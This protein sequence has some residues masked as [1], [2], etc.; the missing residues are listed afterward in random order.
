[1]SDTAKKNLAIVTD[2]SPFSG[3]ILAFDGIRGV[4]A[5]Y[6]VW[7]HL[8][9]KFVVLLPSLMALSWLIRY[10]NFAVSLFFLIS[11]FLTMLVSRR[12]IAR[13]TPKSYM[14]FIASRFLRLYPAYLAALLL[15][16]VM[17]CVT[18]LIQGRINVPHFPW[19]SLPL[20]M[21]MLQQWRPG[22]VTWNYPAWSISVLWGCIL[23]LFPVLFLVLRRVKDWRLLTIIIVFLTGA[24]AS[25]R[26]QVPTD[27]MG[28]WIFLISRVIFPFAIGAVLFAIWHMGKVPPRW[29]ANCVAAGGMGGFLGVHYFCPAMGLVATSIVITSLI[30]IVLSAGWPNSFIH[31]LMKKSLFVILGKMSYSVYLSHALAE[32]IAVRLMPPASYA[33]QSLGI[34]LAVF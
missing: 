25:I 28:S 20:E 1:M 9:A 15:L 18:G 29:L 5:I 12:K 30:F 11:G 14:V 31:A 10:G 3:R 21:L 34:R 17:V 23:F 32:W 27:E 33:D 26:S 7:G 13:L 16:V 2:G 4:A 24:Y 22:A 8:F 6:I 19:A